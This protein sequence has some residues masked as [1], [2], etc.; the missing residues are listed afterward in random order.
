MMYGRNIFRTNVFTLH[1]ANEIRLLLINV[2]PI[3]V[4]QAQ[5]TLSP[6]K[7]QTEKFASI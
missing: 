7:T 4:T 2:N 1:V 6:Y 3:S 5:T